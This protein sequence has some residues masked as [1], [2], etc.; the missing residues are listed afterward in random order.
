VL[1]RCGMAAKPAH[2][3]IE[4]G[5]SAARAALR[6]SAL[7][8]R[9]LRAAA[10]VIAVV[11]SGTNNCTPRHWS[12][13]ELRSIVHPGPR[14]HEPLPFVLSQA[15]SD[16]YQARMCLASAT[17]C[18]QAQTIASPHFTGVSSGRGGEHE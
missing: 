3:V 10:R 2:E 11:V 7:R 8:C 18:V 17:P 13:S 4:A 16:I 12:E 6:S 1:A 14:T 9:A 15:D 5:G